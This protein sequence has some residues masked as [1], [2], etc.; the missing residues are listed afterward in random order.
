MLILLDDEQKLCS[1][2]KVKQN[3]RLYYNILDTSIK[4][5]DYNTA[6]ILNTALEH[7]AISRLEIKLRKILR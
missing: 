7:F 6:V 2:H 1:I 4:K 3:L 5:K